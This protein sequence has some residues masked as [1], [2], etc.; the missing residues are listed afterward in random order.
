MIGIDGRP[1][2]KSLA[3]LLSEWLKFRTDTVLRRLQ[4]RLDKIL[5]R[6][7]ILDGLL[8]CLSEH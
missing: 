2:V 5:E 6:L 8:D 4:Y 7:H 3:E 1:R